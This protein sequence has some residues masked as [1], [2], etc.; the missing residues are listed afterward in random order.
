MGREV[1]Q[2]GRPQKGQVWWGWLMTTHPFPLFTDTER[3]G[4]DTNHQVRRVWIRGRWE[5]PQKGQVLKAASSFSLQNPQNKASSFSVSPTGPS[6]K[7]STCWNIQE[8]GL[9]LGEGL[10]HVSC[11]PQYLREHPVTRLLPPLLTLG[12]RPRPVTHQSSFP[13]PRGWGWPGKSPPEPQG[14]EQQEAK[15]P[16]P[17]RLP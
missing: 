15:A 8:R 3:N 2:M 17:S 16:P 7:V 4:P 11:R 6:T 5:Q 12:S 10:W 13:F 9:C 1:W 14:N